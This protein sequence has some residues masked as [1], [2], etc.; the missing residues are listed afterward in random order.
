MEIMSL[1][2]Y[3]PRTVLVM[4]TLLA[5]ATFASAQAAK[6]NSATTDDTRDANLRAYVQLLRSD[7][8]TEKVAIITEV[9]TFTE[10]EDA[11]FWPIYREYETKLAN[12]NDERLKGIKEYADNYDKITDDLADRLVRGALSLEERRNALKL[13]VYNKLKTALSAKTAARFLQV[14]NQILLL[15]DL[16]IASSLPIVQ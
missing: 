7:L 16:Q 2:K 5:S 9:M 13:D 6:P 3:T 14:E 1:W 10:D 15:L 8:R 11:K 4:L 12:L